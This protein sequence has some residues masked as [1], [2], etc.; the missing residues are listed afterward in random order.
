MAARL[1]AL[2][3]SDGFWR[4]SLADV[5]RYPAPETSGTALM[6]YALA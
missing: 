2:Q 5:A 6:T 4:A 3:G 1:I